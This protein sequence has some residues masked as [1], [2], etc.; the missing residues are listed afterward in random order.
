MATVNMVCIG[1]ELLDG[2]TREGNGFW[3]GGWLR[4]AGHRLVSVTLV[5]DDRAN[6]VAALRRAADG[7]ALVV[8]SGG[9]GP[10]LDDITR[11]AVA[12]LLGDRLIADAGSEARLRAKF[13]RFGLPMP[14]NNLRQTLFPASA[15][16]VPNPVG[17]A[18]CFVTTFDGLPILVLPGVPREFETVA[19]L[20][21]PVLLPATVPRRFITRR[22]AGIGE[23]D[24]ARRMEAVPCPAGVH[25]TWCASH[26]YVEVELSAA[27]EDDQALTDYASEA[28]APLAPWLLPVDEAGGALSAAA[29]T[30]AALRA[31]GLRIATA[32]SCTG[33][34][35]AKALTEV[36]GSSDGFAC[37]VVTYSNRS[38]SELL[39]LPRALIDAEG[40]VSS[41]V[42]SAMAE[43]ARARLGVQVAVAVTGVAGPGGGSEAKPVGTVYVAVSSAEVTWVMKLSLGRSRSRHQIRET[44]IVASL[45]LVERVLSGRPEELEH[46]GGV[47]SLRCYR[48]GTFG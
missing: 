38:K 26:P 17:T 48:S 41:A 15:R 33:G 30:L 11:D 32:E 31:Q 6:I 44:T 21:L 18:D 25:V 4:R 10:T 39:G 29:A 28:L 12:D 13:A 5:A 1:D 3:L 37:G 34:G 46:F 43:G 8:V 16:V 23:S 40:A 35:I 47:V 24:L 20:E 42:A 27:A 9:L 22:T 19:E 7:A 45:R 14:D 36:A 2:R